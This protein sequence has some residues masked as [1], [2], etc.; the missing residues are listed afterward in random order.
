MDTLAFLQR[1]LPR[2]GVYCAMAAAGGVIKHKFFSDAYSLAAAV[3]KMDTIPDLSVYYGIGSYF[4]DETG[5]ARR[6]QRQ[7]HALRVVAIDLDVGQDD[8]K[9]YASWKEALTDLGRFI[10]ESGMPRPLII[11]S[12]VGI[13]AYWVLDKDLPPEKWIPLARA[14]KA[15]CQAYNLKIDPAVTGDSARV[16]RPVGTTNRKNG[17]VVSML[18]DAPDVPVKTLKAA[19][20]AAAQAAPANGTGTTLPPVASLRKPSITSK[21]AQSLAVSSEFPPTRAD[22]V[23]SKCAQVRWAVE[24]QADVSEPVWYKLMGVAAYCE[25]PEVT[26]VKWSHEHPGHD[27]EKTLAKMHQWVNTVT[28]PATCA[29]FKDENPDRCRGCIF[30]GR[31]ASPAMLGAQREAVKTEAPAEA[32]ATQE[33]PLPRPFKRT[34]EGIFVT[35]DETDIEVCRFDIYPVSYGKDESLGYEVVR[36]MWKR[37]HVGW[38]PLVLR[39]AYLNDGVKDFHTACTDQGILFDK[40][41]K[42]AELF[43]QMLRSYIA[44]LREQ[45]TMTNHYASMGWKDNYTQFVL[46]DTVYRR[47][48]DGSVESRQTSVA[49]LQ[50]RNVMWTEA[51]ELEAWTEFTS[52]LAKAKMPCH[53]FALLVGMSAPLYDF[54]G[55]RGVT[56]SLYGDTGA[57]KT[58]AQYWQQSVW[59]NPQKLHFSARFTEN[60]LYSRMATMGH[61]PMTID[62]TTTMDSKVMEGFLYSVT[63][64]RDKARLD[65][66]SAEREAREWALPVTISTNKS[67]A[68]TLTSMGA[69][70]EAQLARILELNMP[71]HPLFTRDSTAGKRIYHFLND[72]HGTAGRAIVTRLLEMGG[73]ELKRR[74][75]EH[76]NTFAVKYRAEFSGQERYWEQMI[77]LADLIGSLCEE[78]GLIK[79]DHTVAI[80]WVL[81]QL[82]MVRAVV[83]EVKVSSIDMITE[84][85][86]EFAHA[87]VTVY[88]TGGKLPT[89]D[90]SRLPRGEVRIRME[91]DRDNQ[92]SAYSRL[93]VQFDRAHFRRWV[94]SNGGDWQFVTREMELA[95]LKPSAGRSYMARG[96]SIKLP[97]TMVI[98][99]D[100]AHRV[101]A[102]ILDANNAPPSM[103]QLYAVK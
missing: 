60:A 81:A 48:P 82:C 98:S 39:Q 73:E 10:T 53:A 56:L 36:F 65:K 12:G 100:G 83:D 50:S 75:A 57:G 24:H 49:S 40:G 9:K 7:V 23:V 31:V 77:V 89:H 76:T 87:T 32:A 59:G 41:A 95:G 99:L 80:K 68:T 86:Q 74:V 1:V 6:V 67:I 34:R 85:M 58:L 64:G 19:L 47:K 54:A 90:V 22:A 16:L 27:E 94:I 71:K 15:I 51:G 37:E 103:G 3:T 13:H 14:T 92:S 79:F 2:E 17:R 20:M 96:T 101:F 70:T 30:S 72:T 69:D 33:V 28:G 42:T 55:L 84:Y 62:E 35:V 93:S 8:T 88:Y 25:D 78:W 5:K 29:N 46:G 102:G 63:Q 4:R 11:R 18:L 91:L 44:K 97:Q 43:R 45:Q 61:L 38:Q 26:A 21:L 52:L 66:T